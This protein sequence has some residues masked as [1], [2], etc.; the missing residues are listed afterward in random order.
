MWTSTA[1]RVAGT[2]G[3][4]CSS[5]PWWAEDDVQDGLGQGGVE[6]GDLLDLAAHRV[7]AE[8]DLALEP[9][10]V[11]EVDR[12]RVVVVGDGLADVVQEGAGDGDLAVDAGEEVGG[13]ADRLG[14]GDRVLEQ[15]VAVGLVVDL[16]RRRV[17]EARP[18]LRV[19][20]RRSARAGR[21]AAAPGPSPAAG[22]ACPRAPRR[23]PPTR[24]RGRLGVVLVRRGLAQAGELDLRPPALAHLEDAA[25]LDRRS[26]ARRARR[27]PRRPPRRPPRRR[28]WRRR[29]PAAAR[30]RRC[31]CAAARA[32]EPRRRPRPAGRPRARRS[33]TLAV[34]SASVRACG[35]HRPRSIRASWNMVGSS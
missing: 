30:A 14:D 34:I 21:A 28:R 1:S 6:A 19:A 24:R 33:G 2:T 8:R 23:R 3:E 12:Q 13:G 31:A 7:V 20:R 25:D 29:A 11:G 17:A 22:A 10:G 16:R 18:D 9:A 26:P 27:A 5:E 35:A 4:P 15:A 32:R